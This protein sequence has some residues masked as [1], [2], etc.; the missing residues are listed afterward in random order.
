MPFLLYPFAQRKFPN[1]HPRSGAPKADGY[2]ISLFFISLHHLTFPSNLVDIP[3][4]S[5]VLA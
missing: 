4:P 3:L 1:I 2:F 5:T